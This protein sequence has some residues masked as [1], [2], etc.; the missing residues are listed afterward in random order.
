MED[1]KRRCVISN[2]NFNVFSLQEKSELIF[3]IAEFDIFFFLV[4]PASCRIISAVIFYDA[5]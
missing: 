4:F 2:A 1:G 3:A 5:D